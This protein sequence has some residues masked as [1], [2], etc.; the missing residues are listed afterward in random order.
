M[1]YRPDR[2][3]GAITCLPMTTTEHPTL[4]HPD[5]EVRISKRRKKTAGAHWEGD[6]IVVVVPVHLRGAER[7]QMV[8]ELAGRLVRHRPNLHASDE[9]L[10]QT[11]DVAQPPLPRWRFTHLHP[12]VVRP[13]PSDGDR[14]RWPPV[15]SAYR[16]D[17]GSPL[18][19]CSTRSSST[20]S[21]ICSN[22][23]T[24]PVSVELEQRYPRRTDADAFLEGYALGLAM[25]GTTPATSGGGLPRQPDDPDDRAHSFDDCHDDTGPRARVPA[26]DVDCDIG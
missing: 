17:C 7:D 1:I 4:F 22:P 23:T 13:R 2:H 14:A 25:P 10:E 21:P 24:H 6:R 16:S 5:V 3:S 9:L 11:G 26:A 15:R 20:S 12:L 8:D 19:G 18:R